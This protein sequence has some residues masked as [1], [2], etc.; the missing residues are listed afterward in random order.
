MNQAGIV[1]ALPTPPAQDLQKDNKKHVNSI[2]KH[3]NHVV[4]VIS[5]IAVT[6]SS[7][8][9]SRR[10]EQRNGIKLPI[11]QSINNGK[12]TWFYRS[13]QYHPYAHKSR[14]V[15]PYFWCLDVVDRDIWLQ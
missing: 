10:R 9:V 6:C 3:E 13:T 2:T 1:G 8:R 7:C 14:F 11:K 15:G 12:T 4:H 5:I